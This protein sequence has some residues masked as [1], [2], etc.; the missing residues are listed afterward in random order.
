[1]I[2]SHFVLIATL[3]FSR[4]VAEYFITD[5]YVPMHSGLSEPRV[6]HTRILLDA[7]PIFIIILWQ[8]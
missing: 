5:V 3:N 8:F 1:M 6:D 7:E 4:S 2:A